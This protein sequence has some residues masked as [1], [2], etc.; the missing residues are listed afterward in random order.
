MNILVT[1]RGM[2]RVNYYRFI[3]IYIYKGRNHH[4]D[5]QHDH[6]Y[7]DYRGY[8]QPATRVIVTTGVIRR[9]N[10][11]SNGYHKGIDG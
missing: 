11:A 3:Y 8:K 4:Y 5:H 1:E 6:H 7:I 10:G 9:S 2:M